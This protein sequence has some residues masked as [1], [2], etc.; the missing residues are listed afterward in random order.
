[1]TFIVLDFLAGNVSELHPHI[2]YPA[3]DSNP[4]TAVPSEHRALALR[5][6]DIRRVY[7]WPGEGGGPSLVCTTSMS[8]LQLWASSQ[9]VKEQQPQG[10]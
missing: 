7:S 5:I 1:M 10:L 4:E 9:P 2:T 3:L 8:Q 6:S